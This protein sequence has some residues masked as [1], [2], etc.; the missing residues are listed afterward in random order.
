MTFISRCC[1]FQYI[2]IY[3]YIY[4]PLVGRLCSGANEIFCRLF[5]TEARSSSLGNNFGFPR[6]PH[7][8]H[9]CLVTFAKSSSS[10]AVSWGEWYN[11]SV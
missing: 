4:F 5:W 11:G 3:I 8:F 10:C 1:L 2:Y 7:Q 9:S 6:E